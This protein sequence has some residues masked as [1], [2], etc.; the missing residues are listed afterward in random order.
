MTP[1][2]SPEAIDDLV[3]L[4]AYIEQDDPAVAQRVALHIIQNVETLLPKWGEPAAFRARANS[5]SRGRRSSCRIAWLATQSRF[6]ASSM[7][8]VDG[9]RPFEETH[10]LRHRSAAELPIGT[11]ERRDHYALT[12]KVVKA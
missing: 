10:V 5:W 4:R 1:I 8:P 3:A 9:P 11:T 12:R 6:C 7:V 2:W